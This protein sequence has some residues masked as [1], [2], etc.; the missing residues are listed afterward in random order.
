MNRLASK[1]ALVK[2]A[3]RGIGCALALCLAEEGAD[4]RVNSRTPRLPECP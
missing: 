1:V 4:V 2:G 3:A